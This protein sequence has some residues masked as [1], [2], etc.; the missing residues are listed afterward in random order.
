MY[1]DGH[2]IFVHAGI[3]PTK[4]LDEQ[5][6]DFLLWYRYWESA[7]NGHSGRHVMHGHT[8]NPGG[9]EQ[10]RNRTKLDTLARRTGRLVVAV[11]DDEKPGPA[12]ESVE[13]KKPRW[14]RL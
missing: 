7:D 1:V 5:T 12:I 4:A 9:P 3:D 2:R 10:Y 14:G 8:S 6:E 11:F 13:G